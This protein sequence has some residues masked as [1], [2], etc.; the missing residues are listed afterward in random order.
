MRR[1][2]HA[3]CLSTLPRFSHGR[4]DMCLHCF[5]VID[6]ARAFLNVRVATNLRF[7]PGVECFGSCSVT[8]RRLRVA[9]VP[10]TTGSSLAVE[11]AAAVAA[12]APMP[13]LAPPL[14]VVLLL[15]AP[16]DGVFL[17]L[18]RSVLEARARLLS[19]LFSGSVIYKTVTLFSASKA[20]ILR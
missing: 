15:L 20:F 14:A 2:Y 9:F 1:N 6:S 7:S 16:L 8:W 5:F 12:P 4:R 11:D 10:S 19:D 17:V 18:S 3:C 13:L